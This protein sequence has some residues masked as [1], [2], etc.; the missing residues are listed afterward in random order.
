MGEL[1]SIAFTGHE[2]RRRVSS[3]AR[4]RPRESQSQEGRSTASG[5]SC[6]KGARRRAR[7]V[8]LAEPP[9][10]RHKPVSCGSANLTSRVRRKEAVLRKVRRGGD[11]RGAVGEGK[12]RLDEEDCEASG[13]RKGS[14]TRRTEKG[15]LCGNWLATG[16]HCWLVWD[17]SG[18]YSAKYIKFNRNLLT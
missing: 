18:E 7:G 15:E 14:A 1:E 3:S 12:G 4:D 11:S 2:S 17:N 5:S 6:F 8:P 9:S 10:P 16:R 13:G